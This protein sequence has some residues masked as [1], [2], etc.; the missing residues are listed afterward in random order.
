MD[1]LADKEGFAVLYPM[2]L[3]GRWAYSDNRPVKLPDGDGQVDD[4]GFLNSVLDKLI[5][6]RVV[7]A[8]RIYLAGFSS[9]A[10]MA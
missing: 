10:L 6:E 9:G 1:I 5:A 3:S 8:S 2:G 4:I 7:D